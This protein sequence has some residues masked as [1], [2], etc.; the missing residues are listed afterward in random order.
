MAHCDVGKIPLRISKNSHLSWLSF[1]DWISYIYDGIHALGIFKIFWL[2]IE[3]NLIFIHT[4][5]EWIFHCTWCFNSTS[6]E[7][8]NSILFNQLGESRGSNSKTYFLFMKWKNQLIIW[9]NIWINWEISAL[10]NSIKEFCFLLNIL[11]I[12]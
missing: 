12:N 8:M 11:P 6:F 10:L 2:K 3:T 7:K 9:R 1:Q 4:I 5:A